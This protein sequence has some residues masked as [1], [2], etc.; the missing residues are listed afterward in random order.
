MSTTACF[1]REDV[2]Y[3]GV[4]YLTEQDWLITIE[5]D[6]T[7]IQTL[8]HAD[9]IEKG[10]QMVEDALGIEQPPVNLPRVVGEGTDG[11]FGRE[12]AQ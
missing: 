9:T 11:P 2:L 12:E 6:G 10:W 5:L 7:C 1:V 8:G 3:N 4:A